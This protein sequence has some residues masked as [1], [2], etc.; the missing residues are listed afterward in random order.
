VKD[1]TLHVLLGGACATALFAVGLGN[2]A[3]KFDPVVLKAQTVPTLQVAWE[4]PPC[5]SP[6]PKVPTENET[7][8]VAL[9]I[10]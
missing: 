1:T 3:L 10:I 9:F 6:L 8:S 2:L 5:P 7:D 4:N